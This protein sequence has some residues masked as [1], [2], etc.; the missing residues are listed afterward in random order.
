MQVTVQVNIPA[1]INGFEVGVVP[2]DTNCFES[3]KGQT[4]GAPREEMMLVK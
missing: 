1:D 3:S 2:L 4:R